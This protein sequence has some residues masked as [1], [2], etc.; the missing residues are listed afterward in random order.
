MNNEEFKNQIL[1]FKDQM[2][3]FKDLVVRELKGLKQGQE[4]LEKSIEGLAVTTKQGF[5]ELETNLKKDMFEQKIEL[6]NKIENVAKE[7]KK[8]QAEVLGWLE[9][10]ANEVQ[11]AKTYQ[12]I[13]I[14]EHDKIKDNHDKLKI[15]VDAN[16]SRIKVLEAI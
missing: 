7:A 8:N 3:G 13:N 16:D 6:E 15:K 2:I 1:S 12:A 10:E 5:D 14:G 11:N 4:K 9:K